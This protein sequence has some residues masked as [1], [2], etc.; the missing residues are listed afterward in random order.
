M[1]ATAHCTEVRFPEFSEVEDSETKR[2]SLLAH[3]HR[4]NDTY[5]VEVVRDEPKQSSYI[6]CLYDLVSSGRATDDE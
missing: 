2:D 6:D 5:M 3:Y 1:T 4:L